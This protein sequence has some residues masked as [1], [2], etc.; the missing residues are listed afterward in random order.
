MHTKRR[1]CHLHVNFL[2][3]LC[4]GHVPQHRPRLLRHDLPGH[5]VAMVLSHSGQDLQA[6][7][8]TAI[9]T[10]GS[11]YRWRIQVLQLCSRLHK[12]SPRILDQPNA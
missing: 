2:A 1:A 12:R 9:S 7:H 6:S 3:V 5:Q 4:E 8:A 10:G 11:P